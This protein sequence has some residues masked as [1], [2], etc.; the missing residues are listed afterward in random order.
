GA[1]SRPFSGGLD[2]VSRTDASFGGKVGNVRLALAQLNLTVGAFEGNF[3]KIADAVTRS[4]EVNADLVVFSE[5]AT[6]GYP[7]RDLL[8]HPR[9]ID[10]NLELLDRVAKLSTERLGILI[11]FVDRNPSPDGKRLFNAAA[12]CRNGRVADRRYKALLPTYDVF[13]E[14]RYFEPGRQV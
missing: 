6:T 2:A 12:L 9:F 4:R 8:N 5:L 13:D 11:G 14:D 10:L 7:P 3:R 1:H